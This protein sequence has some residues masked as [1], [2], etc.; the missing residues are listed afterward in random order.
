MH[1]YFHTFGCKVNQYETELLRQNFESR[2]HISASSPSNAQLFVINSCTVTAQSDQKLR[3][4]LRR[5]RRENPASIIALCG[6][7]PQTEGFS[8]ETVPE[9]DIICGTYNKQ[10]LPQFVERFVEEGRRIVEISPAD[11]YC[12]DE[13]LISFP[14][15]TRAI[16]KI[17]DGCDRFCSYCVIPYARGRS[18]SK[19]L[20]KIA[21]EAKRLADA[22][23]RE[24]VVVGINLSDYGKNTEYNLADAVEAICHSGA[25]RVRLG[26]LEPEEL[27]EDIIMRLSRLDNLCPHFHLALQSGSNKI[28]TQM[29]RKYDR[30]KYFSLV[31]ELRRRFA[32]CAI[33]TDIMVGFPGETD[34]DF[35]E[36]LDFV[37]QISFAGA[38]VFPYSQREGTLAAARKDQIALEI[39]EKRAQIMADE[40]K[41]SAAKFR[42]NMVG[43]IQKVLFEHEKSPDFH[44]GHTANYQI[45]KVAHFT[46]TLFRQMLNVL[47]TGVEGD[48]L[49]GE[50]TDNTYKAD[51]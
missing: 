14:Q 46:D 10:L 17:Q 42:K 6:C 11:K 51:I 39:K 2:G 35:A 49:I 7:M 31:S 8:A 36:S 45:V 41:K 28:L 33:T 25:A 27:T 19:P 21:D 24:L 34:D 16:I 29:H 18:R 50:I 44:Q 12:C 3:Q 40:V 13:K 1:V 23:H 9:A 20:D 5:L 30:E 47:I 48:T 38:H 4:Y 22:G 32:D 43:S 26:S 15:K 37:R